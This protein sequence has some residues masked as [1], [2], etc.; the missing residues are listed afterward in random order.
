MQSLSAEL[1]MEANFG[2]LFNCNWSCLQKQGK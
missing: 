1:E 2:E